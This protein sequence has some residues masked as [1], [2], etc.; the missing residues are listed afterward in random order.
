ME[1]QVK[2]LLE[3]AI[4]RPSESP[5][6]SPVI[7]VR[8]KYDSWRMCIGYRKPNAQTIKNKYPMIEDLIDELNGVAVFSKL[9]LRSGYHQVRMKGEDTHKTTF[10][11]YFGHYEYLVMPF[12]LSNAPATFLSLMNSIFAQYLRRFVVVFLDD[13]LVYNRNMQEHVQHLIVVLQL[14]KENQLY[15]KRSKCVFGVNQVEYLGHVINANGVSTSPEK[16]T[17]V[18]DCKHHR[19]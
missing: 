10:R 16:I 14:S 1:K 6:A 5:Y 7:L 19:I 17:A 4:I 11:I 18:E 3:S 2:Q 12:G 8:K 15:A 9:D 13:V